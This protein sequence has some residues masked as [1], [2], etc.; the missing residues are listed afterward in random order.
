M[1]EVSEQLVLPSTPAAVWE[2]LADPRA[3]AACIP[4]AA[5]DQSLEDGSLAGTLSVKFG[6]LRVSFGCDG[7]LELDDAAMKGVLT[8]H[9]RD[10]RG[11]TRF[12]LE[13]TFHVVESPTDGS[14][15]VTLQ[16]RVELAGRL[17]SVIEGGASAVVEQMTAEFAQR[18]ASTSEASQ[19]QQP[20]S[21][22]DAVPLSVWF[23]GVAAR[24]W[25]FLHARLRPASIGSRDR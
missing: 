16:A 5:L 18:L 12:K 25:R 8:A 19:P 10:S 17:A 20:R 7:A 24:T 23:R 21:S 11:G 13:A 1:I 22:A 4:G 6:P 9:G 14:S 2:V 15:A 3:I